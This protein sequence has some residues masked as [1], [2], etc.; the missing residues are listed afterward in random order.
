MSLRFNWNSEHWD[1]EGGGCLDLFPLSLCA[2]LF[3][4][5]VSFHLFIFLFAQL[6][7]FCSVLS[8]LMAVV[9]KMNKCRRSFCYF[10]L[11]FRFVYLFWLFSIWL[12]LFVLF[13]LCLQYT[14]RMNVFQFNSKKKKKNHIFFITWLTY[15]VLQISY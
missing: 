7:L 1:G 15:I 6:V 2:Y 13:V 14:H 4:C 10:V 12:V 8:R 9:K 3:N 5:I 11:L